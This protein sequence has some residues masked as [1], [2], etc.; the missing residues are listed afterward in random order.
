MKRRFIV[1]GIAGVSWFTLQAQPNDAFYSITPVS[2]SLVVD[3]L[4]SYTL[5][6]AQLSQFIS[7]N[8][9]YPELALEAGIE[10]TIIIEFTVNKEGVVENPKV[11]QKLCR[12]CDEEALRIVKRLKNFTPATKDGMPVSSL[13]R[14]PIR[15]LL[16]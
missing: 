15:L 13:M 4:P 8:Y 11:V 14:L 6:D 3:T 10:G 2:D 9:K 1:L 12:P 5:G 16:Q 7:S